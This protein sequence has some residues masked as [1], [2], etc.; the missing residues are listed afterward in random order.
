[1][2]LHQPDPRS[3]PGLQAPLGGNRRGKIGVTQIITHPAVCL[4]PVLKCRLHHVR[5]G[6]W[7]MVENLQTAKMT[8]ILLLLLLLPY[9]AASPQKKNKTCPTIEAG[10]HVINFAAVSYFSNRPTRYLEARGAEGKGRKGWG[11]GV[12]D[13]KRV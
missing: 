11:C 12:T 3:P 4:L 6:W 8:Q 1:M 13:D 7:W 2:S 10:S 9:Q 5:D